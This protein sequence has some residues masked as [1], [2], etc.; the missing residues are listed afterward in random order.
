MGWHVEPIHHALYVQCRDL[1]G[2]EAIPTA[3]I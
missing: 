1:A 2:R 3:A